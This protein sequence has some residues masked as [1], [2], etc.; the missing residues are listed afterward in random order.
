VNGRGIS[1]NYRDIIIASGTYPFPVKDQVV[2][3]SDAAG[4]VVEIGSLVEV[5][6]IGDR[7]VANFDVSNL[8]GPQRDWQHCH[9]G[10]IDGMLRQYIALPGNAVAK[11]PKNSKLSLTQMASLVCTG[12]A[13][14]NALYGN[15][16]LRPGQTVLFQSKI[17]I[18]RSY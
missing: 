10:P 7:V 17:T 18:S 11:I 13:A 3:C 16:P 5:L 12:T 6:E 14:W 15:I 1:P 2:P 4:E 9:G 8:Y